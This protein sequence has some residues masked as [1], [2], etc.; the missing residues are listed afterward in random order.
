M[1]SYINRKR[2][3]RRM[4]RPNRIDGH[5]DYDLLSAWVDGDKRAGAELLGRHLACLQKFFASQ[6]QHAMEDL[7]Q[8]TMLACVEGAS[9]VRERASFKAYLLGVARNQLHS[10]YRARR[11]EQGHTEYDT[12]MHQAKGASLHGIVSQR[13]EQRILLTA[14]QSLPPSMRMLLELMYWHD[15]SP[16]ELADVLDI[17]VGAVHTRLHRAKRRLRISMKDVMSGVHMSTEPGAQPA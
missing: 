3:D 10:Y 5:S 14:L 8:M 1:S 15:L 11:S 2:E 9:R 16:T 6:A 13:S 17:S 7:I 12:R 4:A